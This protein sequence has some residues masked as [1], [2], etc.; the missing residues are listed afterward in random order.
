MKNISIKGLEN[1]LIS[2][3][4]K[5][6]NSIQYSGFGGYT[7]RNKPKQIKSFANKNTGY[8]QVCL[9]NKSLGIKVKCLYVHRLVAETYLPNPLNLPEVNHKDMNKNNNSVSNLEWVTKEQNI[10]HKVLNTKKKID[11]IIEN[12]KL[13]Q[14]GIE[15]Y[16]KY[17]ML[18]YPAKIW[19]CN[20]GLASYILRLNN[21]P[22][23]HKTLIPL[24][25]KRELINYNISNN[26][27]AKD[28]QKYAY[29]KYK[30]KLTTDIVYKIKRNDSRL[31][32]T[33]NI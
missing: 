26:I 28:L 12:D 25:I 6:Y 16:Y 31:F 17:G 14:K 3:D 23:Y 24:Y 32:S 19:N 11:L 13:I 21:I 4:G 1:Y 10:Q 2:K 22:I 30:V 29:A 5:V 15:E 27:S 18:Y 20:E 8:M 33:K 7:I 9:Q